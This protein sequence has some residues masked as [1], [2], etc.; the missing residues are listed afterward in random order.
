M[1]PRPSSAYD[2][3]HGSTHV[4]ERVD[5]CRGRPNAGRSSFTRRR[6][7]VE[8][9]SVLAGHVAASVSR[10]SVPTY[11]AGRQDAWWNGT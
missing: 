2:I 10:R 4:G 11:F 8:L 7:F 6:P 5:G 1:A 9:R 3:P